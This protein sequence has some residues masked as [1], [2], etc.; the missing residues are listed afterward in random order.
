ML[1]IEEAFMEADDTITLYKGLKVSCDVAR[2]IKNSANTVTKVLRE[3][4]AHSDQE[5]QARILQY[6]RDIREV[7]VGIA[8]MNLNP[9]SHSPSRPGT[10]H[11]ED[12]L[13]Q[14]SPIRGNT[15]GRRDDCSGRATVIEFERR[16]VIY[17]LEHI[18]DDELTDVEPGVEVETEKLK[19]L[20]DVKVHEVKGIIKDL[21]DAAGKYAARPGCDER[22]VHKA[23]LQCER[24]FEWTRQ[25]VACFRA[26]QH[27][28]A[29][30]IPA[31]EITFSQFNPAGDI[32]IYEFCMQFEE[33]AKGYISE[34]A[35]AHLLFSKYLPKSLTDG[36]EE[37]KSRKH[38]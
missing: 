5:M 7:L 26:E 12:P 24:A 37:L 8:D 32:S 22:L 28:L 20:H 25:V 19:D 29:G 11:A 31:R 30:N 6:R 34:D 18:R 13:G 14:S 33:W 27:H 17:L 15:G 35:K 36:Y 38:S 16:N 4:Y 21:R 9:E 2:S 1:R 23:Q 10:E 3:G